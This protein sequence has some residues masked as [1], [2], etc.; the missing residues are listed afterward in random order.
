MYKISACSSIFLC[1]LGS[2][3]FTAADVDRTAK[4]AAD[5]R[6]DLVAPNIIRETFE[7]EIR[8]WAVCG[9][10]NFEICRL[11]SDRLAPVKLGPPV[12]R[13]ASV[14]IWIVV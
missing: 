8:Q 13:K 4:G 11:I 14:C 3:L 7:A 5:A 1:W 6:N 10:K 12:R 9:L 2:T